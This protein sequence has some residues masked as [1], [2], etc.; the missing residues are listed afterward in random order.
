MDS[1]MPQ[2]TLTRNFPP[3]IALLL[4]SFGRMGDLLNVLRNTPMGAN[5]Q[6]IVSANYEPHELDAIRQEFGTSVHVI[7]ERIYGRGSM[8]KAYNLAYF[9][10]RE[11]AF[12]Y[13]ALWADDLMP[14]DANWHETLTT[15]LFENKVDFG[16]FSTEECHKGTFG[17]NF[18]DEIPNA[19]FFVA[20]PYVLGEFFLNPSLNAYVGDYEVCVRLLA[21]QVRLHLLP[22]RLNHFPT[23]NDT[24]TANTKFYLQDTLMFNAMHPQLRG[25]MDDVVLKG[26][27][28]TTGR[29]VRDDGILRSSETYKSA[30]ISYDELISA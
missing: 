7:D 13:V 5:T 29:F 26:D 1:C 18:F 25:R 4:P 22:V 23:Q 11:M 27:Y 16:I 3:R 28:R 2:S 17:W 6:F 24:R 10:A 20:R 8:I 30:Y 21:N 19:H 12:D 15:M 9:Y 14:Q